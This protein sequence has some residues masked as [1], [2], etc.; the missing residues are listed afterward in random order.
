MSQALASEMVRRS[1]NVFLDWVER[2]GE[3]SPEEA[4]ELLSSCEI[5][6]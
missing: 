6:I 1:L 3:F 4:R 5:P 2:Q